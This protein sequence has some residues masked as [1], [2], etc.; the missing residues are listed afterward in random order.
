MKG[1]TF[2][3][4]IAK[5][6]EQYPKKRAVDIAEMVGCHKATVTRWR[7][8]SG[9]GKKG[10]CEVVRVI[11]KT[12]KKSPLAYDYSAHKSVPGIVDCLGWCNDTFLSPD[13]KK[14]RFC[15]TCRPI[16]NRRVEEETYTVR[17]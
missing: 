1:R 6:H 5:L 13:V 7:R 2:D 15:D 16:K 3:S 14:I 12:Y 9:Y 4:E 10:V 17:L 11:P 8:S